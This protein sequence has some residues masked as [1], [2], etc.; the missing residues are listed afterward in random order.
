MHLQTGTTMRE[1]YPAGMKDI[2]MWNKREMRLC[3]EWAKT[4]STFTGLGI[5]DQVRP[6]RS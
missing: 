1:L 5:A 2:Q 4:F 3:L 6:S